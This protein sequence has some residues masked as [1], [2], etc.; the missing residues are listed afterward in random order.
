MAR[1]TLSG[2]NVDDQDELRLEWEEC[3]S[4]HRI[5]LSG[6]ERRA[7]RLGLLQ[8]GSLGSSRYCAAQDAAWFEAAGQAHDGVTV[9]IQDRLGN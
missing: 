2:I 5:W 1:L 3:R 4:S 9:R 8:Y 6:K 7:V